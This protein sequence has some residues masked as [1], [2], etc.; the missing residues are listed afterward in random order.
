MLQILNLK[1]TIGH[2]ADNHLILYDSTVSKKFLANVFNQFVW[3][4]N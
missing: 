2:F 1:F 3:F 4:F